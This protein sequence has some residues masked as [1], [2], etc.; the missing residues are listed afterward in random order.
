MTPE[1]GRNNHPDLKDLHIRHL[2]ERL[3]EAERKVDD[4][5]EALRPFAE[6]ARGIPDGA[7][8]RD[9]VEIA[10]SVRE[11]RR[12]AELVPPRIRGGRG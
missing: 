3:Q 11:M 8:E 7:P 1:I 4:L 6:M 9:G 10:M 2:M 12:A 5:R